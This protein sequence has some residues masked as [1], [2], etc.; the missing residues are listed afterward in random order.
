LEG[1]EKTTEAMPFKTAITGEGNIVSLTQTGSTGERDVYFGSAS[2]REAASLIVVAPR[3]TVY[4][5]TDSPEPG[6]KLAA[7]TFDDGPGTHTLEVLAALA[8]E[9]VPATFFVLGSSAAAHPEV[10]ERMRAEGH[11]IENH[12]WSHP[13]LT[14][15]SAAEFSSQ[16]SRTNNVIGGSR[17]LRPP[18]GDSDSTVR[19]LASSMGLRLAFW[20]VDTRDWERQ[21]VDAIMSHVKAETGPGAI[22]LMH[23]GG[24]DRVQTVAAIPVVIDWLFS[25]GYSLTTVDQIL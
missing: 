21:E 12:T 15:A 6:Q 19:A 20:T 14:K 2:G 25:E 11:E 17:Y 24:V 10:I 18:Y 22:I 16:I 13:W 4:R 3:D 9:H 23:D 1:I 8:A 5:V 7:L